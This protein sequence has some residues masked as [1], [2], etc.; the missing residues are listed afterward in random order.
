MKLVTLVLTIVLSLPTGALLST[1]G[2][3]SESVD[4]ERLADSI[5]G[6]SVDYKK[7]CDSVDVEKA[8][9]ALA[10]D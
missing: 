1:F 4:K 3:F 5:D 6:A 10:T 8:E 7:A 2:K 9:K